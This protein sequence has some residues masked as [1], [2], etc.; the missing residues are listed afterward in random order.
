MRKFIVGTR[1]GR[2]CDPGA[3]AVSAL[4]VPVGK[5][6]LAPTVIIDQLH[7]N[8]TE[9]AAVRTLVEGVRCGHIHPASHLLDVT[10]GEAAAELANGQRRAELKA[11]PRVWPE[12]VAAL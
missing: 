5:V 6:L 4:E 7:D 2:A 12:P 10:V 11:L 8:P 9:L 1:R 3:A